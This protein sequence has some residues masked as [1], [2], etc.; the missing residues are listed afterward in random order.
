[1]NITLSYGLL[2]GGLF[3][4]A[5]VVGLLLRLIFPPQKERERV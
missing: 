1:M 5:V 3:I 2:M 4:G